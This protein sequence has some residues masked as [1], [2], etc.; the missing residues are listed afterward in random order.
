MIA[1]AG[2][3]S[4]DVLWSVVDSVSLLLSKQCHGRPL[5]SGLSIWVVISTAE[6]FFQGVLFAS[7]MFSLYFAI[8][9]DCVMR[10]CGAMVLFVLS[11]WMADGGSQALTFF[12]TIL[13][14]VVGDSK[15]YRCSVSSLLPRGVAVII[16]G[17]ISS[18]GRVACGVGRVRGWALASE[19]FLRLSSCSGSSS[20][21]RRGGSSGSGS[22]S[23]WHWRG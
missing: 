2:L 14:W 13:Q 9:I 23:G 7:Q 12:L 18:I 21:G 8:A 6:L 17:G 22:G 4:S 5:L 16:V 15:S 11:S 19:V 20:G 3:F 10:C 1:T